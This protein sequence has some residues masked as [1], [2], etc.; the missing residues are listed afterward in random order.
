MRVHSEGSKGPAPFRTTNSGIALAS[1]RAVLAFSALSSY[2]RLRNKLGGLKEIAAGLAGSRV[3][4]KADSTLSPTKTVIKCCV[5]VILCAVAFT[6]LSAQQ[7]PSSAA[8]TGASVPRLVSYSGRLTDA[9]GKPLP[10][11]AGV[12]FAIYKDQEGGAPVWL[13]TQNVRPDDQARYTVQLGATKPD[14]LPPDLF[15]SGE[16]RWLGV[17]VSG[18]EEQPR[19]LLLSVPYALKA[20]DAQTL[21]G[22]PPSAFAL[23]VPATG[24]NLGAEVAGPVTPAI[25]GSPTP[26]TSGTGTT[27]F[28]PLWLDS[29]GTLGN[30]VVFQTGSGATA[31]VGIDTTTPASTLDVKGSETVRGNLSLPA[32]GTATSAAGKISQPATLTA[33]TFSSSTKTAVTQNFR[34]QA[35]PAGNNTA[36]AS[37]TLNLLFGRGAAAPTE[38]GLKIASNGHITFASGQTFP[39]TGTVTSVGL[40]A[41]TSDFSVNASPIT[42][43]GTLNLQ[44]LVA[45]TSSDFA[46]AIVKRDNLGNF[47]A[48]VISA[49]GVQ[50][51]TVSGATVAGTN[52]ALGPFSSAVIGINQATGVV[53]GFGVFGDSNSGIG[54]GVIGASEAGGIG[55]LGQS[56][57]HNNGGQGVWGESVGAVI[58]ANGFGPDGVDG[59]SHAGAGSGVAAINTTNGDG[60]YA[61]S[62]SGL[63]GHFAGD[64]EVNGNLS[65]NGG[66]FK[67]DHPLDP[68]NKYLYH[69]FVESP[70]MM[71]IYN[72]RVTTDAEGNAVVQLPEWFE[73]LNRDFRYQLTVIG[74][75]AQAI[76]GSEI[77]NNRFT[78]RTDK[79]N[80]KISWQVTGIRQDAWAN[81]HRIPTEQLK[82]ANER[83]LYQHP[84]L[85]GMPAEKSIDAAKHPG[86]VKAMNAQRTPIA[87]GFR[88]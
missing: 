76:V 4:Y 14:G 9:Q 12:T 7:T 11:I 43:N 35:E 71:N 53:N 62:S 55:M 74:Q 61:S 79:P 8:G 49:V 22:L 6:S 69:S 51:T 47:A 21:G 30:S 87:P 1:P 32:T 83:G 67:I 54:A 84:E 41:P 52:S 42:S 81:A 16:A 86:A 15:R 37:G 40:S 17:R 70:D 24:N 3:L 13:E 39:G 63:A 44:W 2:D 50:A 10:G 20:A 34:F 77:A 68:A 29:K 33:S 78:V 60:L 56:G 31:K 27:N 38:T 58:S 66:S 82:P 64:V 88:P 59:I 23:A 36:G 18:E 46:N 25:L 85:F 28:V 72:G 45:P 65:K 48:H 57:F 26:A 5:V 19:V 75:F 73:A 80:V